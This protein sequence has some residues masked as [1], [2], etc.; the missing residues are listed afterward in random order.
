MFGDGVLVGI[1]VL[2]ELGVGIG[3][4]SLD[5]GEVAHPQKINVKNRTSQRGNIFN[6]FF[7]IF[8]LV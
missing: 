1:D 6:L 2:A 8:F 7:I 3:V 5:G 4:I